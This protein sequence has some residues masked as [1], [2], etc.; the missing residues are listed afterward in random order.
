MISDVVLISVV[1][2]LLALDDRAGW[3]SLLGEPVFVGLIVGA[4]THQMAAAMMAGVALQLVWFSIA[5][6]R[7][8]RRPNTVVGGVVGIGAACLVLKTTG[9]TRVGF[10]V[11]AG[12]FFGLLAGE[13]GAVVSRAGGE[14]RERW[15]VGFRLPGT[16]EAATRDLLARVVASA[17]IVALVNAASVL[18]MLP[19]AVGLG[20]ALTGRLG[21]V[22]AGAELWLNTLP[23][24]AAVTVFTAFGNRALGRYAALGLL[25]T[26]GVVWL[27]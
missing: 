12:V 23:A 1:A 6:A 3:Q 7:G 25:V 21:G 26:L 20:D 5:A 22:S 2:G 17:A 8:T 10:V 27:L 15:L 4:I 24:V 11:A 13:A 16:P 19:V 9:D 14:I 18:V